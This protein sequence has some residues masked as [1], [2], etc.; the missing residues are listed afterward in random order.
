M[1]DTLSTSEA[2]Q[3]ARVTGRQLRYW[4][5]AGYVQPVRAKPHTPAASWRWTVGDVD[6]AEMLGLLSRQLRRPDLLERFAAAIECGTYLVLP[7]GQHE[8]VV[9]WRRRRYE[10]PVGGRL[11]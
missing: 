7:D 2:A 11:D 3:R 8:V 9:S 10:S 4:A 6:R 5:E 1:T